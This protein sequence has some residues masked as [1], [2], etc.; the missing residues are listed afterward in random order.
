MVSGHVVEGCPFWPYP[1]DK[2][3]LSRFF[4]RRAVSVGRQPVEPGFRHSRLGVVA[5]CTGK[6][7]ATS[8][9]FFP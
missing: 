3:F 4:P 8:N 1:R 5:F 2:L 6:A 7:A 9:G